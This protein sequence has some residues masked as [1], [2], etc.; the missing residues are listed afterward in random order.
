MSKELQE[1]A[2]EII[3][4]LKDALVPLKKEISRMKSSSGRPI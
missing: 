2:D 1:R 3:K 4:E